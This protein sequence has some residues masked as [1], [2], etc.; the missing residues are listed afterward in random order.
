[1]TSSSSIQH[2]FIGSLYTI[3]GIG[4]NNI[5]NLK[6]LDCYSCWAIEEN[7]LGKVL[8]SSESLEKLNIS[9]CRKITKKFVDVVKNVI[10]CRANDISLTVIAKGT[11]INEKD[12]PSKIQ[13]LK[14][15]LKT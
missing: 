14:F 4:L 15:Q 6:T 9:Y 3:T 1:M 13:S 12:I 8:N 2:L 5:S 10:S 7:N 11:E